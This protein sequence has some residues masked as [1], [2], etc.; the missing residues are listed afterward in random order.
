MHQGQI[1]QILKTI[2]LKRRILAKDPEFYVCDKT[3][4]TIYVSREYHENLELKE[5]DEVYGMHEQILLHKET[6]LRFR[7]STYENYFGDEVE[8]KFLEMFVLNDLKQRLNLLEVD[9]EKKIIKTTQS[10]LSFETI[11]KNV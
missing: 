10:E 5:M 11:C 3:K 2:G 8:Y 1:D 4:F 6:G 7:Y 9:F